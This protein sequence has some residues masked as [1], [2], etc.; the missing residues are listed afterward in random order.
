MN[1]LSILKRKIISILFIIFVVFLVIFSNSSFYATKSGIQLWANNVVPSLFPFLVAVELLKHTNT[2]YYLSLKL[3][4][5]MRPLFNLPG[6]SAFPFIMGFLSGYPVGAK[7]VTELYSNKSCSKDEAERMLPFTNNSGP[8]FI[9]GT[10]GISF[11]SNVVLGIVLLITHILSSIT[12]GIV[13][14]LLSKSKNSS[15]SKCLNYQLL[16]NKDISI[17]ELGEILGSSIIN[18]IKT[19]LLIGGF[20]TLFSVIITIIEKTHVLLIISNVISIIFKFDTSVISSFITGIIEFTNGLSKISG[21][22]LKSISINIVLSSFLIGFGGI[23]VSLQVLS[24][25]SKY[26]LSIKKY[27]FGKIIQAL[28]SCFYTYLLLKIPIFDFNL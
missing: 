26:H 5:Y 27:F 1:M 20:V 25:I 18:S 6:I 12:F 19:V 7:I 17:F 8:L 23:S 21:I 14:G 22:H 3:D 10:V 28:I 2:I 11:Y 16:K 9:I 15:S 4:K 24:I 13:S